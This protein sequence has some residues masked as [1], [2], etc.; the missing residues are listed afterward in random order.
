M[1]LPIYMFY[2]NLLILLLYYYSCVFLVDEVV[3]LFSLVMSLS[4]YINRENLKVD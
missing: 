1:C 2:W 4:L 3:L